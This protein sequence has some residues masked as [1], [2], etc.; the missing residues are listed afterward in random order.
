MIRVALIALV[1]CVSSSA[2]PP[3]PPPPASKCPHVADHLLSLLSPTAR[4]APTEELD[5]VRALFNARCEQDRWSPAAQQC[6][7]ALAAKE[8]VNR[9]AT[10]LTD[11]QRTALEQ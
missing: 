1:A 6:F 2:P 4:E 3:A 7:L 9:C 11:E 10:L 5:R 8:E